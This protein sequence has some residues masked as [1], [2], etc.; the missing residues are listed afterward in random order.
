MHLKCLNKNNF[1]NIHISAS[2]KREWEIE[3]IETIAENDGF[4]SVADIDG[5]GLW[6]MQ[7]TLVDFVGDN[8]TLLLLSC[9]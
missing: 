8:N 2:S 5:R 4:C 1:N 7:T 3:L 6:R 9:M